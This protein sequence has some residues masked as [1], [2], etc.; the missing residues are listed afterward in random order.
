[1]ITSEKHIK[2]Y[3][4]QTTE[5]IVEHFEKFHSNAIGNDHFFNSH[6]GKQ[7]LLYADWI[8]SGRLYRPIED[9]ITNTVG[10]MLANTHSFSNESGKV[11]T[12]LYHKARRIIKEHVHANANANDILVTTGS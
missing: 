6:Y 12:L 9:I 2:Q 7:H 11:T 3:K 8:A 10:P 4:K 1:M 5:N